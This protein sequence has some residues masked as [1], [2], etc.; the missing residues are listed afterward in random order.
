MLTLLK[1][2]A[3]KLRHNLTTL[4]SQPVSKIALAVVLLLDYFILAS[5]FQGLAD[6]TSQMHSPYERIPQ[7]CRNIVIDGDWNSD[8]SLMRLA[9]IADTYRNSYYRLAKPANPEDLQPVC[10]ALDESLGKIHQDKSLSNQLSDYLRLRRQLDHQGAEF[11]RTSSAYNTSLLETIADQ[12]ANT[13]QNEALMQRT[14]EQMSKMNS[15]IEQEEALKNSLLDNQQVIQLMQQVKTSRQH[16]ELLLQELRRLNFWYP[17][18]RLGMEMVFLLPLILVIYFWHSRS[19]ANNR[20]YQ[21]LVSSH[22]LVVVF[23]PVIFK[24]FELVYDIIPKKLLQEIFEWLEAFNLVAIWHY[25]VIFVAVIT[26]L[27]LI[28]LLQKKIF[29]QD[30]LLQK[31]IA[32]GLCQH[33]G[34]SLPADAKACPGCGFVQ[35]IPCR[36]CQQETYVHGRYCRV[37]GSPTGG[38]QT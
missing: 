31:R 12:D 11:D 8:D 21:I 33:C 26:A 38:G 5:I 20:P 29:S 36:H 17:V 35:F 24:L 9:R 25:L 7:H 19:T 14:A 28:Y 22:L 10:R 37:C 16:R 30:R 4:D 27:L 34:D 23:I 3:G 32:K 6:H 15:L 13:G 2:I 1:T 18:K